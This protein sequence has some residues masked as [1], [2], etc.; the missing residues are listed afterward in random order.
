MVF[1]L[2]H[3]LK[4]HRTYYCGNSNKKQFFEN[5]NFQSISS[6]FLLE[7]AQSEIYPRIEEIPTTNEKNIHRSFGYLT[8]SFICN[9]C[10]KVFMNVMNILM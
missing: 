6:I 3:F 1:P 7:L 9:R 5:Q 8:S 4:T 10:T 2:C